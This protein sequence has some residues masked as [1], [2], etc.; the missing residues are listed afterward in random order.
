MGVD[1]DDDYDNDDIFII[2]QIY[3]NISFKKNILLNIKRK[4]M[5]YFLRPYI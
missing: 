3:I 4:S 5:L 2:H 1:D